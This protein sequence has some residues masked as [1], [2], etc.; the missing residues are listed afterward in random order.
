MTIDR[1]WE[2]IE[3]SRQDKSEPMWDAQ[4]K[5]LAKILE[6]LTVPEI[7]S[8][9]N[10]YDHWSFEGK[11]NEIVAAAYLI[12][13]GF[14]DDDSFRVMPWL[15]NQGREYYEKVQ[16]D[17]QY[18]ENH[19]PAGGLVDESVRSRAME[20]LFNKSGARE[21]PE[22]EDDPDIPPFISRQNDITEACDEI[23]FPKLFPRLWARYGL[24][25]YGEEMAAKIER[26]SQNVD[27]EELRKNKT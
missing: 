24:E 14:G 13:G 16:R 15:I 4:P 7:Q 20:V 17:P 27:I 1:F 3:Q 9:I 12:E 6:Q 25:N 5:M 18:L 23:L 11:K 2:I 10:H 8:F 26:L 22:E 21:L 19:D